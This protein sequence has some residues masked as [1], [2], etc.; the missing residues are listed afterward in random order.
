MEEAKKKYL[1]R[2]LK[3]GKTTVMTFG[4]YLEVGNNL[5]TE[6]ISYDE[7]KE[8][9]LAYTYALLYHIV[10]EYGCND[11]KLV[12]KKLNINIDGKDESILYW[13]PCDFSLMVSISQFENMPFLGKDIKRSMQCAIA[14]DT[15]SNNLGNFFDNKSFLNDIP[16]SI[17]KYIKGDFPIAD[18]IFY[19]IC[20]SKKNKFSEMGLSIF[21]DCTLSPK[22]NKKS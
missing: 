9:K 6:S 10:G 21:R 12:I 16:I 18:N 19:Y 8:L 15:Y 7:Y 20:E 2:L 17:D 1:E 3:E 14:K 4:E 11:K 5:E 22:K 13:A